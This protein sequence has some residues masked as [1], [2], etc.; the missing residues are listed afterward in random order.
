MQSK[1]LGKKN[2]VWKEIFANNGYTEFRSAKYKKL[3]LSF[4]RNGR[5]KRGK[6]TSPGMN[7]VQFVVRPWKLLR[8]YMAQ[9]G[10]RRVSNKK[11]G[12]KLAKYL[13][14]DQWRK[15]QRWLK[16][17]RRKRLERKNK[18]RLSP[19]DKPTSLFTSSATM[20]STQNVTGSEKPTAD[21]TES[22]S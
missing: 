20:L 22:N 2:C 13:T 8:L 10:D 18:K 11:L 5:Q 19:T 14:V 7:S 3:L 1:G 12:K 21:K 6:K 15:W 16:Q 4:K 9:N 17:R